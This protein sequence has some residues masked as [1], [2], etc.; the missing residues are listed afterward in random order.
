MNV[1]AI[2][3]HAVWLTSGAL[4]G[5]RGRFQENLLWRGVPEG[6]GYLADGRYLS[7]DVAWPRA[8]LHDDPFV[9]RI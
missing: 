1:T 8:A 5:K 2:A 7:V 9:P 3:L 4:D 6:H